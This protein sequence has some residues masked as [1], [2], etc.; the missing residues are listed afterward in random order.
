MLEIS[1]KPG[2]PRAAR[3]GRLSLTPSWSGSLPRA[4]SC[5]C[6][7][8]LFSVAPCASVDAR[9]VTSRSAGPGVAIQ[10]MCGLDTRGQERR[11]QLNDEMWSLLVSGRWLGLPGGRM[12]VRHDSCRPCLP[13]AAS[14][15]PTPGP[16][17]GRELQ[18]GETELGLEGGSGVL[19]WDK[20]LSRWGAKPRLGGE[21]TGPRAGIPQPQGDSRHLLNAPPCSSEEAASWQATGS[22]AQWSGVWP[23]TLR[24]WD[25]IP[26]CRTA[27]LWGR[28]GLTCSFVKRGTVLNC[29][30]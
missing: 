14:E 19:E 7:Y 8:R 1:P 28:V 6:R 25:Q 26:G 17:G 2:D 22:V 21:A 10:H 23:S 9:G 16:A 24:P 18:G 4:C 15:C 13:S 12:W 29:E 3:T 11:V 30:G 27:L 20:G 5:T